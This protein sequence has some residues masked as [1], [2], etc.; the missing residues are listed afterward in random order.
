M[1]GASYPGGGAVVNNT[2]NYQ[3]SMG[4]QANEQAVINRLK[5]LEAF[6]I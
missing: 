4:V 3:I 6:G 2:H 5:I 1:Q